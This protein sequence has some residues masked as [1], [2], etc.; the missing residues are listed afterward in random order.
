MKFI[1]CINHVPDTETKVRVGAD[2]K[3]LDKTGVN[4]M[5]NPY[6]EYAIEA[7]LRLR[8]KLTG[9]TIALSMGGDAHK[10]TLRKALA[11]GVDKAILL[12]TD[13]VYD[14]FSLARA[15]T[16][17]LKQLAPDCILFGKQSI[18]YYD[19]QVPGLVG[20]MM[21]WPSVSVVVKIEIQDGK[22]I[23]E[24]EIEGGH[25]VVQTRFPVVLAAQKGLYEP[26][27]PSLKGIM[28]AKSKPIEERQ[29]A[30]FDSKVEVLRMQ[31]PAA[32][33]A[34]KIVGTDAGA[35]P[36][37]VRLLQEEAKVF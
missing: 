14:S 27:Y 20:E 4:F 21:G 33:A 23:C 11:M 7:A 32:K 15:L 35:V 2:G 31:K 3:T 37:L 6:D 24:R 25:E 19:E 9:E 8:E 10:E 12:K 16:E 28:A 36:E 30:A 29:P 1:V 13:V 17:C 22:L 34:G 26:R 18:D 5:L